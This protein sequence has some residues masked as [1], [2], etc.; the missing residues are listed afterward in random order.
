MLVRFLRQ[1]L[2][3]FM[4]LLKAISCR[5]TPGLVDILLHA[6]EDGGAIFPLYLEAIAFIDHEC[7]ASL[8]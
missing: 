5:L 1:V 6:E 7:A 4:M 2:L 8:Y 3:A